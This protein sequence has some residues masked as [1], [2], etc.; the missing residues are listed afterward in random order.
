MTG[1]VRRP[2]GQGT[3]L[4][5]AAIAAMGSMAIH[6]LVPALPVMAAEFAIGS[7]RTQWTI[8]IYLWGLA[9]GQ[10]LAGPLADRYGRRP[11]MLAGLAAYTLAALL[12]AAAHALPMLVAARMMQALGGAGGVV[13]A[14]VMV[15]DLFPRGEAA[16]KQATLMAIVMISPALAPVAGGAVTE[17]IGWRAV[18]VLLG[19]CGAMALAAAWR[20]LPE[21]ARRRTVPPAGTNTEAARPPSLPRG[22]ARLFTNRQFLLTTA[23]L[24]GASSGLY[25]FL[26]NS[27]FVL[28]NRF[29]LSPAGAGACL[30]GIAVASIVGTRFVAPIERRGDALIAGTAFGAGGALIALVLA[31]LGIEG[32][33]PFIAPMLCI[34]V[35][36]G[37]A[38]PA[39]INN[40]IFAEEGLAATAASLAGAVQM[41]ASGAGMMAL[42]TFSP[43]DPLRLSMGL[44]LT[45][46][47]AFFSAWKR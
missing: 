16:G 9:G 10:L 32:P 23:A 33:V 3:I 17:W 46:G 34:G 1:P 22:Y 8:S 47:L 30:L 11:V 28:I 15:G 35:G 37:L 14:R 12:G 43:I 45:T 24:A 42:G 20:G 25:M 21:T 5:L 40:A 6:M 26:A 38:G 44:V 31:L 2:G 18:L 27:S 7:A 4:I 29:G 36:A 41:L 39:A 19:L 13:A